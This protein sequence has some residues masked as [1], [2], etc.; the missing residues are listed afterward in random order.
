MI[1]GELYRRDV[2]STETEIQPLSEQEVGDQGHHRGC[3]V[4]KTKASR[5]PARLS[6]LQA[7]GA[8][9]ALEPYFMRVAS[10]VRS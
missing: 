6:L 5:I 3:V 7:A 1:S 4:Q 2:K 9:I 8:V 10:Q